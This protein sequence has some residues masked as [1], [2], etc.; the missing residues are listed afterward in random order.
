MDGEFAFNSK[1]SIEI[2]SSRSPIP[3]TFDNRP[4]SK[5]M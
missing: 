1:F 4:I 5:T 2:L 3:K